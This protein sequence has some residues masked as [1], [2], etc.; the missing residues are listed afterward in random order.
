MK[1]AYMVQLFGKKPIVFKSTH[2]AIVYLLSNG[3]HYD[4]ETDAYAYDGIGVYNITRIRE[5]EI[6][7]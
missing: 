4:R 1:F 3:Y 7:E 6:R 2:S 5:I